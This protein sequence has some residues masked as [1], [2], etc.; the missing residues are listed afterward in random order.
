MTKLSSIRQTEMNTTPHLRK[1][2]EMLK[3][4]KETKWKIE[5]TDKTDSLYIVDATLYNRLL[6][7]EMLSKYQH[8]PSNILDNINKTVIRYSRK[9]RD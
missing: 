9:S 8:A 4:I 6:R 3:V 1:L 5:S 2:N 7:N